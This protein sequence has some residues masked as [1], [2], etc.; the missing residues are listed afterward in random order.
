MF[1]HEKS[2]F[3][4]E[5]DTSPGSYTDLGPKSFLVQN[6]RGSGGGQILNDPGFDPCAYWQGIT[7][8]IKT[9]VECL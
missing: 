7:V 9:M 5:F 3:C 2:W 4:S 8:H 6:F 1:K